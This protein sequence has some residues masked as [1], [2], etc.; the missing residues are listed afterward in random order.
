MRLVCS[1]LLAKVSAAVVESEAGRR[2]KNELSK[3]VQL[4]QTD[5]RTGRNGSHQQRLRCHTLN[6]PLHSFNT[7]RTLERS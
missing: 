2:N 6:E 3:R 4:S 5:E 7:N 1:E